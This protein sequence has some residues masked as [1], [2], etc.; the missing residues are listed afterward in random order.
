MSLEETHPFIT[1]VPGCGTAR[2]S[3]P[4]AVATQADHVR[5]LETHRA[6]Y[7]A[8][9]NGYVAAK[10]AEGFDDADSP[11]DAAFLS[12]VCT[13]VRH[14]RDHCGNDDEWVMEVLA[15][16]TRFPNTSYDCFEDFGYA[17]I[18]EAVEHIERLGAALGIGE[19]GAP[20]EIT[21]TP[22]AA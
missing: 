4:V 7:E 2:F 10:R 1:G 13:Y 17:S 11:A 20:T 18:A 21:P 16:P 3:G 8:A 5:E 6:A 22:C 9:L 14:L 12:A 19:A 15:D